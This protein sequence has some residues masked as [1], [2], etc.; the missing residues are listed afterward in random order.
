V[1]S[2][3]WL[4]VVPAVLGLLFLWAALTW[5]E[6]P[7]LFVGLGLLVLAAV[8]WRAFAGE[9]LPSPERHNPSG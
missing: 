9:W 3:K 5:T 1:R 7:Q 4:A 6:W 2:L 8:V